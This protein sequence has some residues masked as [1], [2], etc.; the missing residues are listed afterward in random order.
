MS[1]AKIPATSQ[2]VILSGGKDSRYR[3][4]NRLLGSFA[5]LR[6]TVEG[7]LIRS[8]MIAILMLGAPCVQAGTFEESA[9]EA[10]AM[11][12]RM[13]DDFGG[14]VAG[15]EANRGALG[16]LADELRALG[17]EPEI[18]PFS[19]P[20]WERG[21]DR[22]DLVVP[23]ARRLRVA[24]LAYSQPHAPFEADVVMIG[25]GSAA[26]Y[27]SEARGKV[28]L[29]APG[30]ALPMRELMQVAVE[31]GQFRWR[32]SGRAC[33]LGGT[34]G[35]TMDAAPVGARST[36]AREAGDEIPLP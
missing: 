35:G 7:F 34:G 36:G 10:H 18:D 29:L 24:A 2:P 31:R 15:M 33:L 19:M 32:G 23:F 13:C 3:A 12:T 20:G 1:P 26:D 27:P 25:N 11:L 14:R 5:A 4:Y 8:A 28:A 22:V 16:R 6:M 21:N 9:R 17:V 30:A